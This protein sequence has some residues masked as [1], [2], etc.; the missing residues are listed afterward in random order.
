M[1]FGAFISLAPVDWSSTRPL[2]TGREPF[3]GLN[4]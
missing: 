2:A 1:P 3:P 4:L